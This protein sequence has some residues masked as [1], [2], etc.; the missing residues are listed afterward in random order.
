MSIADSSFSF[1]KIIAARLKN[2]SVLSNLLWILTKLFVLS[3]RLL[4]AEV[5]LNHEYC[6]DEC[7][8]LQLA[9]KLHPSF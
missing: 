3:H 1:D 7:H 2:L 4:L 9:G 8:F 5:S 6:R